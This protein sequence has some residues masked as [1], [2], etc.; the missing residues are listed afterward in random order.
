MGFY[1][2]AEGAKDDA[3]P[4]GLRG[5][6]HGIFPIVLHQLMI[7]KLLGEIFAVRVVLIGLQ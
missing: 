2:T 3:K 4:A 6:L 5:S 1:L 7:V